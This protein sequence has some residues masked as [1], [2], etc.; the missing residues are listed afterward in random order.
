MVKLIR[1]VSD[2]N[3]NFN[4][5]L[6]AGIEL[7][8]NSSI[9]LQ[10]LT[11]ENK[12]A[13][14]SITNANNV[15]KFC[16]DFNNDQSNIP[17]GGAQPVPPFSTISRN[18]MLKDYD[19]TNYAEFYDN[20]QATLNSTLSVGYNVNS[21]DIYGSFFIDY[22]TNPT[23]PTIKF[24]YSPLCLLFSNNDTTPRDIYP[25][26]NPPR[27]QLFEIWNGE[28]EVDVTSMG[29]NFS[30]L[31]NITKRTG[32]GASNDRE[33]S[34]F[35]YKEG[36]QWC[37][38][39]AFFGCSVYNN[40]NNAGAANTNGF[41]IG[42]SYTNIIS[43]ND[44][45]TDPIKD[46]WRDFE[47]LIEK[48]D[49]T[50]RF[51]SPTVVNTEQIPNPAV[52]PYKV[53]I[54]TE[55]NSRLHDRIVFQRNTDTIIGSIWDTSMGQGKL[56]VLFTYDIP[57]EDL[58]K[59]LYPYIYV[60]GAKTDTTVGRPIF[61]PNTIILK[62]KGDV[63]K[64]LNTM[65]EISGRQNTIGNTQNWFEDIDNE[66]QDVTPRLNNARMDLNIGFPNQNIRLEFNTE[67]WKFLGFDNVT[68]IVKNPYTNPN[69]LTIPLGGIAGFN[70][71][72]NR[73]VELINSDN[74]VVVLD[75]N[76]LESF[77]ASKF[78]YTSERFSNNKYPNQ[79]RGRR[80]NILATIPK[81]DNS[82]YLEFVAPVPTFID[83]DNKYRQNI[84]NIKVRV[85]DKNLDSL[86]TVG[87]SLLTLLVDD[88][89]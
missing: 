64:E 89:D 11:F 80:F 35:P 20:L 86:T 66:F 32:L 67:I 74:F 51:I 44:F 28:L 53:N 65:F 54:T 15:I 49:E 83:L 10:N 62:Q 16:L 58:N 30:N 63:I 1:M 42:L 21:G 59:P 24:K 61:T 48:S 2:D 52:I 13:S 12:F 72:G 33:A 57:V 23:R 40:V 75:S 36:G 6:D 38:G 73:D 19:K 45:N 81:N 55:T 60:K 7:G 71:T 82:G 14:I 29:D 22:I 84:K 50:Y 46:E 41:G 18:L 27:D 85:L 3:C 77:D 26:T 79:M 4:A 47:I 43:A 8:Q 69:Q 56:T 17:V 34:C 9:A 68:D 39:S 78:D 87:T 5:N 70:L 25:G 88:K 76:P 31:N 37:K